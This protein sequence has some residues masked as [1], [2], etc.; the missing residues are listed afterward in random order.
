MKPR[1][2]KGLPPVKKS[3]AGRSRPK[4]SAPKPHAPPDPAPRAMSHEPAGT[5]SAV[6][7]TG[8]AS[9]SRTVPAVARTPKPAPQA[10][11]TDGAVMAPAAGATG[12]PP[13]PSRL[14]PVVAPPLDQVEGSS[15]CGACSGLTQATPAKICSRPGLSAIAY[16]IGTHGQFKSS[17]LAAA[18]TDRALATLR[19]RDDDDFSVALIDAWAVVADVLTFYQER[20]ANE[21]YLRTAT[22]P[23][24]VQELAKLVGYELSPGVAA[25]TC[26]AFTVD[27]SAARPNLPAQALAM[28]PEK[29]VIQKGTKVQSIPGPGELPLTFETTEEIEARPEW[30]ALNPQSSV[31]RMPAFEDVS[32]MLKGTATNLAPGDFLL[33]VSKKRETDPGSE[34]WDVRRLASVE[35]DF[36]NDRTLVRW[37][38]PLGS[39]VPKVESPQGNPTVYALRLRAALFGHNAQP[40]AALPVSQRFGEYALVP[41]NWTFQTGIYAGRKEDWVEEHFKDETDTINL[42]AVYGQITVGSWVVLAR[43]EDN[44][45]G[46]KVELYRVTS[47]SEANLADYNISAR[48]TQ[49]TILGEHIE[50]FS[51]R[52]AAVYA[53]SEPLELAEVPLVRPV[54]GDSG[55]DLNRLPGMLIP[56]QGNCVRLDH[57]VPTMEKGRRL[58]VQGKR[59]RAEV[60]NSPSTRK[61][62]LI[63]EDCS[64]PAVSLRVAG[65][66]DVSAAGI[67]WHLLDPADSEIPFL[68][69][70]TSELVR[71]VPAAKEDPVLAEEVVLNSMSANPPAVAFQKPL[72]DI[73][74]RS[75]VTILANA[76]HATHGETVSEVLGSGDGSQAYQQFVLKQPPLTYTSSTSPGGAESTLEI[77]VN[78]VRWHEVPS[79]Y[80]HGPNESIYVT[81]IQDDGRTVVQ[82]G[83]GVTG[84]RLPTGQ[85]NVRATYRRGIGYVANMK[86]GQLS[87]L[88]TRPAGL[89][90][91]M[92]P[93]AFS[94]GDNMESQDSARRN[95]PMKVVSLGRLVSLQ[96]YEDFARTFAHVTKALA[97]WTWSGERHGVVVTAA[98][99]EGPGAILAP[100]NVSYDNLLTS[101]RAY[102]D[103]FVPVKLVA[104]VPVQF[105]LAA[106]VQTDPDYEWPK[107]KGNVESA[108]QASFS[109][110]A[111]DLGEGVA[112]SE[113]I[114]MIQ[115]VPGVTAVDVS[116]FC[117]TGESVQSQLVAAVPQPVEVGSN[118][119]TLLGAELLTLD[120]VTLDLQEMK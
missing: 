6:R 55:Q 72:N 56:I 116:R 78:D 76:A 77:Q 10:A 54:P 69:G 101:L 89:K 18:C 68:T 96:D 73:Y 43:T 52:N 100:G 103:P 102:G 105:R 107:V 80:E 97:T 92:N 81:R 9:V 59:P 24:S 16:R 46:P 53:Q 86:R 33:I 8:K 35:V 22:E 31:V 71:L 44:K 84:A 5:S 49:L 120:F 109:F 117:R 7:D 110:E 23:R 75:T 90:D 57:S 20:I 51:P 38:D 48:T 70:H 15:I 25:E 93:E 47:I 83:D 87:L 14:V 94:G 37:H 30:N 108:L 65:P 113:V 4:R 3:K 50:Y 42:D 1:R 32:V 88:M 28:L 112:L 34:L 119:D 60:A 19:T 29:I 21:S 111:R 95:A 12:N 66:P 115:A 85:D 11:P 62:N 99:P 61:L 40:W 58:V 114:A 26:L 91:A 39:N 36:E 118:Q 64:L 74:D 63:P 45:E 27:D 13:T 17:M 41:P 82:F 2:K 67:T 79:L 106:A 98:G 104:H